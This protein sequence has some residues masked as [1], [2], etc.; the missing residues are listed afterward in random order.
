MNCL[1]GRGDKV[2]DKERMDRIAD[3]EDRNRGVLSIRLEKIVAADADRMD[4]TGRA[5]RSGSRPG[6]EGRS[7][8]P[9]AGSV[10]RDS[11]KTQRPAASFSRG[12]GFFLGSMVK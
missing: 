8:S 2:A 6:S 7:D 11:R 9:L 12:G 3:I 5:R 1:P 10:G 4:R